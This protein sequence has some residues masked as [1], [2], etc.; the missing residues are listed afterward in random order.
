MSRQAAIPGDGQLSLLQTK[1]GKK[2]AGSLRERERCRTELHPR[3]RAEALLNPLGPFVR[4]CCS[5]TSQDILSSKLIN[6]ARSPQQPVSESP[7]VHVGRSV[8]FNML[9]ATFGL[10]SIVM[11][12]VPPNVRLSATISPST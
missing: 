8:A 9:N 12:D 1:S 4:T 2:T 5:I 6:Y 3:A 11:P 7:S 10:R